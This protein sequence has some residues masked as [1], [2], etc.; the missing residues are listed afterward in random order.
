[1]NAANKYKRI[2]FRFLIIFVLL[3]VVF[4]KT[5]AQSYGLIFSSHEVVPEKRTSLDLTNNIPICFSDKLDLSFDIGFVPNHIVY[6]GYIF[7]LVNNK[8]QN[9]DLIYDQKKENFKIVFCETFT[10]IGFEIDRAVLMTEW[11]KLRFIIDVNKGI[12]CYCNNKIW[13]TKKLNLTDNCFKVLFGASNEHNFISRDVPP[14]KIKNIGIKVDGNERSFWPLNES[15]GE[16]ATDSIN[17]I[18]AKIA[19]PVWIKPQHAIWENPAGF[20][21][22]GY[23]SIAFNPNEEELYIVSADSF[24]TMSAKSSKISVSA[25]SVPHTNLLAG[26]QSI[27]NIH[28]NRLYNFYTDQR[29]V[30]EYEFNNKRWNH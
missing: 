23:P 15:A 27:F 21:I 14:M 5:S 29:S 22:K 3:S 18:Q 30:A 6:F 24:Y 19:N 17:Q 7:R 2:I 13:Q 16:N 8:G 28:N 26:N 1:M 9:I 25:L 4:Y 12:T 20:K 11:S 10:D